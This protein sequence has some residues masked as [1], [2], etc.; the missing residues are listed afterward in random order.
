MLAVRGVQGLILIRI[1]LVGLLEDG[2]QSPVLG[3][4]AHVCQLAITESHIGLIRR[5]IQDQG[6]GFS[7]QIDKIEQ[8]GDREITEVAA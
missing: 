7:G 6:A 4:D 8:L 3:T 2:R 1:E 5:T